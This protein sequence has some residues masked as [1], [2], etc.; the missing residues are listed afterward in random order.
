MSDMPVSVFVA[1]TDK[2]SKLIIGGRKSPKHQPGRQCSQRGK[3][4]AMSE[5]HYLV[6][7]VMCIHIQLANA[8]NEAHLLRL[9]NMGS[10]GHAY[11]CSYHFQRRMNEKQ[12]LSDSKILRVHNSFHVNL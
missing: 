5:R 7:L 1:C 6:A 12:S 11:G 9:W 3:R 2:R 10:C 4:A 8:V